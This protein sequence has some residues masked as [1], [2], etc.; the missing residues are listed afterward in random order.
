MPRRFEIPNLAIEH[1]D[2]ATILGNEFTI[3]TFRYANKPLYPVPIVPAAS[4]PWPDGKDFDACRKRFLWFG[5]GGLVRKG[6][7]LVLEAFVGMPDYP[8]DYLW[9]NWGRGGF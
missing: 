6:L 8:F 4:Y 3:N 9:P 1:A 7:D 2:C 5:S